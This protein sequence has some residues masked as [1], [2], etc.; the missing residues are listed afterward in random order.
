MV[1]K[2]DEGICVGMWLKGHNFVIE[3]HAKEGIR[4]RDRSARA[5]SWKPLV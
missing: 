5:Y 2:F 4:R 1:A 3:K